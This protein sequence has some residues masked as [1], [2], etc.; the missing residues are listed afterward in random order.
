M[1]DAD[2]TRK[3]HMARRPPTRPELTKRPDLT[4]KRTQPEREEPR[5]SGETMGCGFP[6]VAGVVAWS[7]SAAIPSEL[8]VAGNPWFPLQAEPRV[9][10]LSAYACQRGVSLLLARSDVEESFHALTAP[11]RLTRQQDHFWGVYRTAEGAP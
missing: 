1:T 8:A 11:R 9:L 4:H 10:A 2:G 7:L 6:T 3:K 5:Y